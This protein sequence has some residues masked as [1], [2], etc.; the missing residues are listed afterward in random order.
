MHYDERKK[1]EKSHFDKLQGEISGID[2][3]LSLIA[4]TLFIVHTQ[5]HQLNGTR[6]RA[7]P[8]KHLI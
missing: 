8:T 3:N 6:E 4:E 7:Q 5:C 1:E 2:F